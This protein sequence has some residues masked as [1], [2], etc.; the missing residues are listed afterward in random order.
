MSRTF[1]KFWFHTDLGGENST[2]FYMQGRQSLLT[3]LTIVTHW[4]RSTSNF[5]ALIG[6]NLTGEFMR[7]IYAASGN[8][9]TDSWSWQGFV[10][11]CDDV[12]NCLFLLDVPSEIELL[13]RLFCVIHGW[14]AMRFWLRN[15][16][17]VK[18]I[19][20]PILD[21]IVF[22]N[23]LTHLLLLEAYKEGWKVSS[24]SGLTCMMTF[25]SSISTGKPEQ[26][27]SFMCFFFFR[28][29]EAK[30]SLCGL[31]LYTSSL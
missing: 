28:F 10:S 18:I 4:S 9:L 5:Q 11:S 24:D 29:P 25:R 2:G 7:K 20:N 23:D 1:L 8:L 21:D 19:G 12:F 15:A 13:T 3:F 31:S 14:F 22:K 17:L 16:P 26:L 27:L 6:Q 30:R